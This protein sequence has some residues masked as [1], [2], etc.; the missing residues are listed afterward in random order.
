MPSPI[1]VDRL[2][3]EH[4][5]TGLGVD[6]ANPRLS[7][8]VASVDTADIPANWTQKSYEVEVDRG[9]KTSTFSVTSS[10][11][12]L[13]PWPAE[14]LKSQEQARVRVRSLGTDSVGTDWSSWATVEASLLQK[15]DLTAS[16]ITLERPSNEQ[17]HPDENGNRPLIFRKRFQIESSLPSRSRLYITALGLYEA[18]VNGQRVG[19]ECLAPG[20]TSYQYR[21]CYQ[22]F[23][24][25]T[26]LQTGDNVITIEVAEGWYSGRIR[27]EEGE[28]NFYGDCNA[29]FAQLDLFDSESS[30]APSTR[31]QTD[32][33]WEGVLSST[34]ASGIYDGETYDMGQEPAAEAKWAPVKTIERPKGALVPSV[35]A[36]I[37]VTE[38]IKPV[39]ITTD[40][41]DKALIDFGQNLVGRI[42]IP[43]LSRSDGTRVVIRY[44]EVLEHGRLG[45]RPLRAAKATDTIIFGQGKALKDWVPRF[46]YHGFR[47]IEITGWKADDASEPLTLGSLF[48]EVMHT[49]MVRTGHFSCSDKKVNQLHQNTVWSMRGNFVGLPTDCPQRDERLG[50]TGDI[51]VFCPT[52]S[53]I[54]DCGGMLANWMQDLLAEQKEDGGIVPLVVPNAMK[55]GPWP[56]VPQAVWDDVVILL[57]WTL[58][59]NFGD[60]EVLRNSWQGMKDYLDIVKRA[61]DGLW[62]PDLW[63]LGDWLDP[64]APP[65][66]PG[67]A[68]TD[69]VLVADAYLVHVTSVMSEIATV[70]SLSEEKDN[71]QKKAAKLKEAFHDKYMAKSGLIVG[72]SQ[73]SLALSIVF[74]L[75]NDQKQFE[76]AASRLGRMVRFAKF[77]VSTGFAGTPVVLDALSKGGYSQLA[78]RML[79]EEECPSWLYPVRKG[80]TTIWERWDSMLEDGSINPGQMTSFNHYAL[81]SVANWLHGNIGGISPIEPGWKSFRFCPVPGGT[82]THASVAFSSPNG[83]IEA[84]WELSGENQ[85][86]ASLSVPPNTSAV[87]EGPDN[88]DAVTLGSGHHSFT[89]TFKAQKWPPTP[90]LTQFQDYEG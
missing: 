78:Y 48:A 6:T 56:C 25:G 80:A 62:H 20:W 1:A 13:V 70:L 60:I 7:W 40:P 65:A 11:T 27:W 38:T 46:T 50:W 63:Q 66:E 49:D 77:R 28:T 32:G 57:P 72:D 54:Y 58:Y 14:P 87:V 47:Y 35:C 53:F 5:P 59:K 88:K 18:H 29:A 33:T 71:F 42:R 90:L 10:V 84:K 82:I 41:E 2:R 9:G 24:V 51:Q 73:T 12:V 68:R 67:L 89:W 15:D 61:D 16:F 81:G 39:A 69:G 19:Q 4:H 30:G 75:H 52:A 74:D 37:T 8:T 22:V 21:I 17:R 36:P 43:S 79:L 86:T 76:V 44:A 85:M 31:I 55:T 34:V 83:R 26:L 3:F 64:N 23:D 45:T